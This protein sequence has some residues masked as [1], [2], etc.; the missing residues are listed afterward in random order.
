M[1]LISKVQSEWGSYNFILVL[2]LYYK[3]HFLKGVIKDYFNHSIAFEVYK[4]LLNVTDCEAF[5]ALF[6]I[7]LELHVIQS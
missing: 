3:Y 1:M 2:F 6:V 4:C 7:C 5:N